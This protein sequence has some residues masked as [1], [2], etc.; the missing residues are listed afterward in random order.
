MRTYITLF[1]Y[2]LFTLS[3]W[4]QNSADETDYIEVADDTI[5]S[6]SANVLTDS[7]FAEDA[8]LPWEARIRERL[9][10]LAEEADE[11]YYTTGICV[12]D[13]T[14]DSLLFEY[15]QHKAMRPASTQKLLTAIAALSVLGADHQ[16]RTRAY[17][18]GH[19]SSDS[20]LHGDIYVVGDFDPAYSYS[21][22]RELADAIGSLGIRHIEGRVYGD[23][24]MKDTLYF[25]N[26]WCWDD[27]PSE[28]E[29]YLSPLTFNRGCATV[30]VAGGKP[31]FSVPTSYL[32]LIDKTGRSGRF[33]VTR[34][35]VH[36]GN[37]FVASGKPSRYS[38][39][40]LSVYRPELYFLC[41]LTDLLH[42]KGIEF[43]SYDADSAEYALRVLPSSAVPFYTCTRTIE[44]ILQR[45]MKKSDNL[46]AES[47]FY[48]L[49]SVNSGRWASWKDGARQV[50]SV[51]HKAGI[52]STY[53]E[54]ADGSGVS[55]YNYVSPET[56][57]AMLRYA[58]RTPSIYNAL[59]PSLPVA[60]TDGTLSERMTRGSA[61]GNVFAKT[62]T[63]SGVSC[64]AGYC[65]A[66]NGN[67]LAFSIMNN[68]LM[69]TSTGR[70]FQDRVCQEL[71]R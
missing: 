62:G 68:G 28:V 53:T 14:G 18:T 46:Y 47:M 11:A 59:L 66:A 40:T 57:V 42:E 4:S 45:M 24:S 44:Q 48:Q 70:N 60:G 2:F 5:E 7:L 37:T 58:F 20:T 9:G 12:Y 71:T 39:K 3:V 49:A 32:T 6:D 56:E 8:Q 50:T 51:M 54:V 23:V 55:L 38:R 34:N 1:L 16:Y 13:L 26:G 41:T 61:R 65:T 10:I 33:N 15:N 22:M 63:V 21:D 67:M 31:E 25:G 69:K 35:W 43:V 52:S 17:H 30:E 64:L 27:A 36:G 19:I 29:A